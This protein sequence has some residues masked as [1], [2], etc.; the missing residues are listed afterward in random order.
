MFMNLVHAIL[1]MVMITSLA[2]FKK[3]YARNFASV[4]ALLAL[5]ILPENAR[6]QTTS[7]VSVGFE[8]G[9]VGEYSNNAHQPVSIKTFTTLGIRNVTISQQTNNGAFGGSQGNDYSVTVTVLFSNGSTS[10]FPAAVNWRDTQGSTIHGI[11]LTVDAGVNDGIT[12]SVRNGFSKTYLLQFVGS[13]RAYAD[14]ATNAD[15]NVVSGNAATNGLLDAL[16]AYR[17]T[18]PASTTSSALTSIIT[19]AAPSIAANGTSTTTITVQLKDVNGKNLTTG[20][21]AVTLATTAGTLSSVTD[22]NNGTYT[23]T[24]TSSTSVVTATITGTTEALAI[25]DNAQV[26]FVSTSSV[27]GTLVRANGSAVS[28][29]SVNLVNASNQIVATATTSV[30]GTYSFAAVAPGTYSIQFE[31]AG[32]FKAKAKSAVGSN[33]G[34]VVSSVTVGSSSTITN[35]DAVVI[36]PAGVIYNS[37]TRAPVA[38]AIASLYFGGTK[39]SNTAL[40]TTLGGAN[41]QTTGADGFYSFVLNGTASSGTY[42][43]RVVAPTG[44]TDAPSSVIAPSGTYTPNLGGG[45]ELIQAQSTAPTG[46]Q[47]T[48]YHLFFNFTIGADAASTSNGVINNHIPIDPVVA[49]PVF[50]NTNAT[51]ANSAAAYSFNYAE[52]RAS[53]ATLG[54]VSATGTGTL[55]YSITA[56]NTS[57]WFAIDATTGVITLTQAGSTSLANDFETQ[58][59]VQTLTVQVSDG[60]RT[61][62]IDVALNETDLDDTAPLITGP[63]G[64]AGDATSAISV[65]ENQTAVTTPTANEAVTWSLVGGEDVAKFAIDPTTGVLTFVAAPDFEVPTDGTTSGSN[66]YIVQVKALDAAGNFSLQTITVT[67]LNLD[68]TGP[69]ITGPSGAAGDATSAISVNE[70]QT[71]VTTPTANEAV[72]WSLVGGEDV[73]KFAIDPT[74]GVLTFVAAPDFEVPTD[75]TTSGSNTY[76]VQVKALDA[77]G[78]FSLQTITVTVLDLD[79]TAPVFTSTNATDGSNN[80]SYSFTYDENRASG[81]TLGTV[82]ATGTGTLRYSITSG[83]SS[84]WF[85]IDATSG[86]ITLTQA[87]STSQAND[88]ETQANVQTLTVQVSDGTR[89]TTIE[90]KLNERNV[91]DV[92]LTSISGTVTRANRSTGGGAGVGIGGRTV[93]LIDSNNNVLATTTTASNGS[94]RF[95]GVVP[96]TY[97]V[98]FTNGLATS[99]TGSVSGSTV[100]NIS[101]AAGATVAQVNAVLIDPSG[102]VYDSVRRTPISNA[103]VSLYFGGT[104][105]SNSWLDLTIG[106]ANDQQ[107]GADGRYSFILASS[108]ASGTYQIRVTGPAGY[109]STESTLIPSSGTVS[110]SLGGGLDNVQ[111]QATA[112]TGTQATTYYLQ[113]NFTIGTDA[114]STSNGI[115]NNHIPLDPAAAP[116]AFTGTNATDAGNRPS[117]NFNYN[118]GRSQGATLG[119]VAASGGY[120]ANRT[121]SITGGNTNGWFAVGAENGAVTLTASGAASVAND[122][123]ALANVHDL[124]VQVS[125]GFGTVSVEVK[126]SEVNVDDSAPLI[127]GPTG[128]SGAT[129]SAITIDEGRTQITTMTANEA[130]TWSIDSGPDA[131]KFRIDATSGAIVFVAAPDFEN[132]TDSDRNNTYVVRIKAVDAAGNISFQTLTVTITNVDE[133][134]RKLGQIADKLR[135]SL[136]NYAAHGLS[137]MLA[138]NE[139]LMAGNDAFCSDRKGQKGISGSARANQ[140]GANL[141]VKYA[142][143]LSDCSRPHQLFA[144]AGLSS[145]RMDGKWSSR[146]FGALRFETK[147]NDDITLGLA[148]LVSR[149]SDKL[150][151]FESSSIS[152]KSLQVNAYG[153]YNVSDTLRTGAFIGYG[154]TWY[155]FALTET[156]GFDLDGSMTGKRKVYGWMLSGDFNLGDTVVTTDAIISHAREMIG[157]ATLAARYLGEDRS[158]IAFAVGAV[159]VT[160][161]S[162][163]VTAPITLSGSADYGAWS[164]LLLSPGLLC[165]DH[166]VQSSGLRCGYQLGA[167]LVANDGGRARFYADYNWESVAGMRRS[168]IAVG[169]AYRLGN[170]NNLELAVEANRGLNAMTR[171]DNRAMLSIRLAQ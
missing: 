136:Q 135:G 1:R 105:V 57:S 134:A 128:G 106:G 157:S 76:I 111:S 95:D 123:E 65:N 56:G 127:T 7:T 156:D 85:V 22:N 38:N 6:A 64:A 99:A 46:V 52:N 80:P 114:A 30:S 168:L 8:N 122:F 36:D 48:T 42:E 94:Y 150:T 73:A 25:S 26:Q 49:A 87:G 2:A 62:T 164:R 31:A 41:D 29:R 103:Q 27:S 47:A 81:A 12:Y 125:D 138:F 155:D 66:T 86:A 67:V 121:F 77:A 160:R 45:L 97:S 70:N 32:S 71:A 78:N 59:N 53:G 54:T 16:N 169:Y 117:Y 102:V 74:T 162:V 137:D 35:V 142:Q 13:N 55:S 68:D 120:S 44:F 126:L 153:R 15:S 88:F 60:T 37:T 109:T 3:Q 118:E 39:V 79:D 107:T 24:L 82:S 33:Q 132:P 69:V 141:D 63:S 108:A 129:E 72:T 91:D 161:I 28:G 50:T 159:D 139:S 19:A 151:G 130:V 84:G 10:T 14:T 163:P 17:T 167:K 147:F 58:A 98:Q 51:G 110:P 75:G 100:S 40:D 140:N 133:I 101:V 119:T 148:A 170:K 143:R 115:G 144:D 113:F 104:K 112:P 83:N 34:H 9:F 145:S 92:A 21:K 171:Q 23:A 18:A 61:T 20:G 146:V 96:G 149:S 5:V 124:V 90:V 152:D 43:I 89:T 93:T 154:N 158:G 131:A 4:L 116:L 11:G 166:D 165:E